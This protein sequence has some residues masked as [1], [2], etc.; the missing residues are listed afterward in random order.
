MGADL[1]DL[2]VIVGLVAMLAAIY[3]G[4]GLVATLGA[5][6]LVT[7]VAGLAGAWRAGR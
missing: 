3:L 4:V 2:L 5:A 6:G 1:W 7:V